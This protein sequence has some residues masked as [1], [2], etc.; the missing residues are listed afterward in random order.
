MK[1]KKI[2]VYLEEKEYQDLQIKVSNSKMTLTAYCKDKIFNSKKEEDPLKKHIIREF[3][4]LL[5]LLISQYDISKSNINQDTIKKISSYSVY[6]NNLKAKN[7][8]ELRLKREVEY[9]YKKLFKLVN[10][11]VINSLITQVNKTNNSKEKIFLLASYVKQLQN[12]LKASN[13]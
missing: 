12:V 1:R 9:D 6:I 3:E 10:T 8:K 5:Y 7:N 11:P 4:N 13:E 2:S